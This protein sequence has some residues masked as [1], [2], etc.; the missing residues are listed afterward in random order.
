MT[1]FT[2]GYG[3]FSA[4]AGTVV[5][6]A[7][8]TV[9][10]STGAVIASQALAALAT[11]VDVA[12]PAAGTYTLSAQAVD[13]AGDHIGPAATASYTVAAAATVTVQIPI[14]LTAS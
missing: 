12:F 7:L 13:A 14:S 1:G 2:V 10:D 8:F 11:S 4:T 3:P 6:G 9:T 5:S